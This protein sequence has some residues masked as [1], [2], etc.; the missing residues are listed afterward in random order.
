MLDL[1]FLILMIVI[2]VKANR[3][4]V[5]DTLCNVALVIG[6]LAGILGLVQAFFL[7][8][9]SIWGLNLL[10]MLFAF[11]LK[12]VAEH[13]AKLYNKKIEEIEEEYRKAQERHSRD[14]DNDKTVYTDDNFD[15]P[16]IRFGGGT[17][18]VWN[19]K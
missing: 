19:G 3:G 11:V 6:V 18:N 8:G 5:N 14:F 1:V 2:I 15:D 16:N 10:V 17:G 12:R 7:K 9:S 4:E 13:F